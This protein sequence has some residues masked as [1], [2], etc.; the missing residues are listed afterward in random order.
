[1][2]GSWRIV[3]VCVGNDMLCWRSASLLAWI[4][5]HR[6]HRRQS[7]TP[8]FQRFRLHTARSCFDHRSVRIRRIAVPRLRIW[9][10]LRSCCLTSWWIRINMIL[11][12]RLSRWSS[13]WCSRVVLFRRE[14]I[15]FQS[16]EIGVFLVRGKN[17]TFHLLLGRWS[18]W[19]RID[20]DIARQWNQIRCRIRIVRIVLIRV[21][22]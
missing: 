22:R 17:I 8:G 9:W 10:T 5:F 6:I 16:A 4:H 21:H 2:P 15:D 19:S 11:N 3:S 18:R 20:M 14:V 1:M 7:P 13:S 12:D